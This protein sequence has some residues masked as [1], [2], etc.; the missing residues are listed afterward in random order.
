VSRLHRVLLGELLAS[1]A[2]GKQAVG[3][4]L[5]RETD[6]AERFGVSRGVV[7]ESLR[8]LE[9]R[10]VIRVK[11]GAG[12]TVQPA[13][14]WNVLDPDVLSAILRTDSSAALLHEFLECRRIIEIE[15]AGLA[16]ARADAE[17]IAQITAAYERMTLCAE[18]SD[19]SPGYEDQYHE[20]NV[21]FHQ[22]IMAAAGNRVLT[23]LTEPVQRA[24]ML[25]RGPVAHREL[26]LNR[27]LPEHRA[28]LDAI[29]AEDPERARAAMGAHLASVTEYV[30]EFAAHFDGQ[31]R[32]ESVKL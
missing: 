6:L 4:R 17:D 2:V 15:C 8:G 18:L 13:R 7:R 26:R 20:S 9:E 25:A 11:H 16:A 29:A 24:Y 3:S 31:R 10:G 19:A 23:R 5:P 14:E 27:T 21:E 32:A 30:D 22:A 28:I 12:A 1:I